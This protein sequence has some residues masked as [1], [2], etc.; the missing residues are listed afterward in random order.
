MSDYEQQTID[1]YVRA[2][3][4][5][6]TAAVAT[7]LRDAAEYDRLNPDR[8]LRNRLANEAFR[9]GANTA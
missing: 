1:K 4:A 5:G 2:Y 3:R 9:I 6:D 8:Q 7:I